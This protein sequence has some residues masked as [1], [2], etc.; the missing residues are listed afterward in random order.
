MCA[1]TG[2]RYAVNVL[3]ICTIYMMKYYRIRTKLKM[4]DLKFRMN[5]TLNLINTHLVTLSKRTSEL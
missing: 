1:Y 2:T 5:I 3:K 4:E